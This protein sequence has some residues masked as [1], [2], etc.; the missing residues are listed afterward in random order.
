M[1]VSFV[2]AFTLQIAEKEG[3]KKTKAKVGVCVRCGVC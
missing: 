2:F 3:K 1:S